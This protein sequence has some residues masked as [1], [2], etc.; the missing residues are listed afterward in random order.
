MR[1]LLSTAAVLV[2]GALVM[3]MSAPAQA[4]QED[5]SARWLTHELTNGLIHNDQYAFDDYGLTADTA[6][7]L[8]AIGGEGDTVR[9][10]RR[11]LAQ[12]VDSWTTGVDFSSPDVYAGSTAKAVVL[13]ETT[14]ADPRSFGGVDVVRRLNNLVSDS[15]PTVG[16][17]EDSAEADYANVIG[18]T[19]AAQ[20]LSVAGSGKADE[21]LRF[22]LK[23]QCSTGYFRLNFAA[24]D[25]TDQTCDG[26]ARATTSAPDTDVTAL[27]VLGLTALPHKSAAVRSAISDAAGW[28]KRH[29]KDNG[30]FGG[31]PATEASNSNSTGL[32]GWALGETGSCN[33]AARAAR[34]V[35]R[36]QVTGDVSGTP[37][38]GD[39]GAI[40]YD[41]TR[42]AAGET[43]GIGTEDR[44]QWRRATAQAAPS[45]ANLNASV[46][47]AS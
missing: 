11:A 9:T 21:T 41:R 46:C 10:I 32:A 26:G 31:G 5:Q 23:Q 35:G 7:A 22:L 42:L 8:A 30:S 43:N 18:Q 25:A 16:R 44:D 36:L 29:Q 13:A 34:W 6:F 24:K 3:T 17:I 19:F 40:A 20:G 38:A 15:A 37:L 45:L 2:T 27:A 33:A 4:A 47:R 1:H 12:H 14:G 28:L 39:K